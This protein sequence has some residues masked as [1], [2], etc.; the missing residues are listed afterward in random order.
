LGE[1]SDPF[2][3]SEEVP[4]LPLAGNL[5]VIRWEKDGIEMVLIPVGR[6]EMEDFIKYSRIYDLPSG[7]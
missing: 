6:F 3:I 1:S 5:E 4:F 2:A 7:Y